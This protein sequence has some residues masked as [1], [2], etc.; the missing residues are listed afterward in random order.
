[1]GIAITAAICLSVG[2]ILGWI[3]RDGLF[4]K[5][6]EITR[7][8]MVRAICAADGDGPGGK[9]D[10]TY[11]QAQSAVI[12]LCNYLGT[13]NQSTQTEAIKNGGSR[14]GK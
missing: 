8:D 7:D 10:L 9:K 6:E 4:E 5:V 2:F 12:P 14:K 11:I 1:M 13:K 3:V